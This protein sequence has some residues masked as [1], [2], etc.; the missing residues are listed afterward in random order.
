MSQFVLFDN[1][2]HDRFESPGLPFIKTSDTSVEAAQSMRTRAPDLRELV[3]SYFKRHR[4]G[5]TCDEV[6]AL[7]GLSHQSASPRIFE[8]AKAGRIV[9]S[10][11]RRRTRGGRGAVVYIIPA[12]PK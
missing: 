11:K 12:T 10:G 5:L 4:G 2:L 6:E 8:L 3:F 9:D 7:S 1:E